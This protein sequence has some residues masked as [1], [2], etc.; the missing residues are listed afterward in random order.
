MKLAARRTPNEACIE[1][2]IRAEAVREWKRLLWNRANY[3]E[4]YE[5]AE[6]PDHS[7]GYPGYEGVSKN[8]CLDEYDNFDPIPSDGLPSEQ[9]VYLENNMCE[10]CKK[11]LEWRQYLGM[12]KTMLLSARRSVETVGK[13]LQREP[14]KD[15]ERIFHDHTGHV[16][17]F[18]SEMYAIM[19]DPLGSGTIR[20]K[21]MCAQLKKAAIEQREKESGQ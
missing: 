8:F 7:T 21:E 9:S 18:L 17:K 6:K 15:W 19:I 1:Y 12:E 5:P 10:A 14:E 13:R 20:I 11:R 2:A 16:G 3:C 4:H